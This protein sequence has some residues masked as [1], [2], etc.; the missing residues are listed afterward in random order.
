MASGLKELLEK[1]KQLR[2]EEQKGQDDTQEKLFSHLMTSFYWDGLGRDFEI[3]F[4]EGQ[5]RVYLYSSYDG[6]SLILTSQLQEIE[7]TLA[8][9]EEEDE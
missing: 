2:E 6:S 8:D 1:Y 3:A 7:L 5:L 9:S 4:I